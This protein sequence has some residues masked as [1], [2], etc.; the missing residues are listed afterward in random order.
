MTWKELSKN[1]LLTFVV[2]CSTSDARI[3]P[4][5]ISRNAFCN[6]LALESFTERKGD[7]RRKICAVAVK[8]KRGVLIGL[9]NTLVNFHFLPENLQWTELHEPEENNG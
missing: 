6:G 3:L 9:I 4:G 7:Y 1:G 2:E 5:L 8:G